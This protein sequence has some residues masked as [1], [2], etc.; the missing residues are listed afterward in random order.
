LNPDERLNGDLKQAIETKVPCRTKDC[1][2][3]KR[4]TEC[5]SPSRF[6]GAGCSPIDW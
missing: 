2:F 1:S 3:L 5:E 6:R 4:F